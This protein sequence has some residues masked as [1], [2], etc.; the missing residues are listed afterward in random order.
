MSN[1]D[2]APVDKVLKWKIA[3]RITDI[4][5]WE[6]CVSVAKSQMKIVG[7]SDA[8]V[9][10]QDEELMEDE[11]AVVEY[12]MTSTEHAY[13]IAPGINRKR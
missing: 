9:E 10:K 6:F 3:Y 1:C 12:V 2:D 4:N 5:K 11:K 8:E 7:M 13:N